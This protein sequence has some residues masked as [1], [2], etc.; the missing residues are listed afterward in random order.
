[1]NI[2]NSKITVYL[3]CWDTKLLYSDLYNFISVRPKRKERGR[4]F[5]G[6]STD[7][8][9]QPPHHPISHQ[10]ISTSLIFKLSHFYIFS[11]FNYW[12]H[13]TFL[14][15]H[16]WHKPLFPYDGRQALICLLSISCLPP[17]LFWREVLNLVATYASDWSLR[18]TTLTFKVPR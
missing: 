11:D 1:M 18:G 5:K 6:L 16:M 17:T 8:L 15:H 9:L 2:R 10:F 3:C 13:H 14:N 7:F 12:L 4:P